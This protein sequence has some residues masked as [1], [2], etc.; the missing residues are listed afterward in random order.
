MFYNIASNLFIVRVQYHSLTNA[1]NIVD[2][3]T[4]S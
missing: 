4:Q 2:G 3:I 1:S